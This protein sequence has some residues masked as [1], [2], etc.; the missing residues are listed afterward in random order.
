MWIVGLPKESRGGWHLTADLQFFFAFWQSVENGH[1]F[2]GNWTVW[3]IGKLFLLAKDL[4]FISGDSAVSLHFPLRILENFASLRLRGPDEPVT[5]AILVSTTGEG[6]TWHLE[7]GEK[8]RPMP[9]A[10]GR[11]D[12]NGCG[13]EV[14]NRAK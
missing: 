4:S 8:P 5:V 2:L 13:S 9:L 3:N 10:S 12:V 14:V 6:A 1:F 7:L 11:G